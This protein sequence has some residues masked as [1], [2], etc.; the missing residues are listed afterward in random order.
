MRGVVWDGEALRVTDALTVRAPGP[1]EARLR[2]LASG[3]CHTD[4]SVML[5]G[6]IKAPVVLGHEAAGVVEE[7]GEG[8]TNVRVGDAVMVSSQTP[9][10]HCR[11]CAKG[12]FT[13]CDDAFGMNPGQ[14]FTWRGQ[15]VYS[16]SN[17]SSFAGQ[18]VVQATQLFKTEGLPP[19]SAALIGCAVSTGY[20]AARRLG[21]VAPGDHVAVIGIGGVG[22]NAIQ[23]ARV[24]GAARIIAVDILA[25][26]AATARQFGADHFIAI[27]P[28]SSVQGVVGCLREAAGNALDVVIECSGAPLAVQAAI[29]APKRGGTCVLIGMPRPG[30]EARFDVLDFTFG[31]KVVAALNAATN[32]FEDF[33]TLIAL[34]QQGAIDLASQVTE[35]WPLEEIEAAITALKA[36]QVTRAVLDH[37][38]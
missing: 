14:P 7:L 35:T 21:E 27:E 16:F 28:G 5:P 20:N 1:G 4:L 24:A 13:N 25:G 11:E 30:T 6:M 29:D 26:K 17:C 23:G 31:R 36:G 8:V 12:R 15:P 32:P 37:T 2:V 9:C 10:L 18:I 19:N 34:G 22:V 3:I 38:R 33:P